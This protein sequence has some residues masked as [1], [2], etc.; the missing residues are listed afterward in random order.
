[1]VRSYKSKGIR[2][3]WTVQ[4]MSAA[5]EAVKTGG[6]LRTVARDFDVPRNTLHRKVLAEKRG[7]VVERKLG[8]KT[9][10]NSGQEQ[11]LV[12]L[13]LQLEK[14]LFGLTQQDLRKLVYQYCERNQISHPFN[15]LDRMAG[16][17]WSRGF[18]KRHQNLS[19]RKP[20]GISIGRAIGFSQSVGEVNRSETV[21][22]NATEQSEGEVNRFETVDVSAT[23]QSR[24]EVNRFETVDVSA[25]EQSG[26][27]VNRS[28]TVEVTSREQSGGEVNRSE[29]VDVS[30]TKQ[31]GGEVN[32]SETVDVSATEQ[33]GGEVNRS[34]TVDVSA[35]EQSG[36]EV[37]RSETVEVTSR[38]QSGGEVNRSETVEVT[39][40]EQLLKMYKQEKFRLKSFLK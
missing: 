5:V 16:E 6:K 8:H 20:E 11:E 13:L 2:A 1:M 7:A 37:N 32:R 18:L 29:T 21:D 31:S 4:I 15:K 22:V 38:E 40:R 3:T 34:E 39:S 28:E 30:A 25:T 19:V 24:G 14:Q 9:V 36:G 33:S 23:E 26:G 12:Q 17:D 27:E 10:L 35:T